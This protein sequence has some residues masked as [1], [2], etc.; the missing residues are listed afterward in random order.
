MAEKSFDTL[1]RQAL[2]EAAWQELTPT[3]ETE[4]P[5]FSPAYLRWRTRLLADPFAW[6]KKHLR[7]LWAKALRT[8]ACI[9]LA[10][11]LT[12]GSLM[13]VSPTVRAAVL[14]WLREISG[15]NVFYSGTVQ[16]SYPDEPPAWR[17]TWL[18]DGWNLNGLML[19]GLENS[20]C[21]W[22]YQ[23]GQNHKLQFQCWW[24]Q[25][26]LVGVSYGESIDADAIHSQATVW[27][28][29]ADF[30]ELEEDGEYSCNLFWQSETGMLFH[31]SGDYLKKP[32]ME[33]IACSATEIEDIFLQDFQMEWV[34]ETCIASEREQVKDV[35]KEVW[36]TEDHRS[37]EWIC[38]AESA[39]ELAKP[40]GMPEVVHIAD[41]IG[42][43]W[44][45]TASE[46][47]SGV[48]VTVGGSETEYVVSDEAHENTLL[49]KD[50]DTGM[51][52]RLRGALDKDTL[53][54]MAESV[55]Q[56]VSG[57]PDRPAGG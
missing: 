15:G 22:T 26:A 41:L 49:W 27:E 50:P 34:P 48:T 36:T 12:L 2:L 46:T 1:L 13:A 33:K 53:L 6:A 16:Q 25:A 32:D 5:A 4:P 57:P 56:A 43:Y 7:P 39:G 47:A 23:D 35:I 54:R 38:A 14:N 10:A 9:L 19:T 40:V 21:T 52:F 44:G 17:P 31:L 29:T 42:R 55:V 20:S 8:A 3:L 45:A 24:P 11:S 28:E 18:P 37:V 51:T 30:Y